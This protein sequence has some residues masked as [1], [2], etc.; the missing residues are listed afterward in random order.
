MVSNISSS[1]LSKDSCCAR[2]GNLRAI[3]P[4][5]IQRLAGKTTQ[6]F[7]SR[8]PN[9]SAKRWDSRCRSQ[10]DINSVVYGVPLAFVCDVT[11]LGIFGTPGMQGL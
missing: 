1:F 9:Y 2:D 4:A 10:T 3:N 7:S 8:L 5:W 6:F 11:L